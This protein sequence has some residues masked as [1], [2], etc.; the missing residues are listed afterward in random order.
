MK[1]CVVR[2]WLEKQHQPFGDEFNPPPPS[3][4]DGDDGDGQELP[5]V[6]AANFE[7]E[8]QAGNAGICGHSMGGHGALTIAMKNPVRVERARHSCPPPPLLLL[9]LPLTPSSASHTPT[10]RSGHVQVR[11]GLRAHRAPDGL[12]LGRQGVHGLSGGGPHGLAGGWVGRASRREKEGLESLFEDIPMSNPLP[13]PTT[14][15]TTTIQDH[16]ATL[17]MEAKG[18]FP[19]KILVDQGQADKFLQG[20]WGCCR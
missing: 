5:R 19:F 4:N 10:P 2:A 6:V 20:A 13:L 14:T 11:L 16:D 8:I 7:K 12:P 18:P 15:T 17:L 3:H 1:E 9:L